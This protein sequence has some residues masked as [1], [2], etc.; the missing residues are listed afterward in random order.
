MRDFPWCT[1][2]LLHP[3]MSTIGIGDFFTYTS[4][5]SASLYYIAAPMKATVWMRDSSSTSTYK[6]V[7]EILYRLTQ[8][9]IVTPR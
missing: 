6:F 5:D 9:E 7:N 3:R 2:Y 4:H 8:L 1:F